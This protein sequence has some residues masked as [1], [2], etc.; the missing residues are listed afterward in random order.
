NF[1]LIRTVISNFIDKIKS[2]Q[3]PREREF[4]EQIKTT[5]ISI[6]DIKSLPLVKKYILKMKMQLISVIKN[7]DVKIKDDLRDQVPLPPC[8]KDIFELTESMSFGD[9]S[10]ALAEAGDVER[11][12]EVAI[13]I[14]DVDGQALAFGDIS[15]TLAK[16]G[17]VE[18]ALEVAMLISDAAFED[19]SN[20]QELAFGDIS[21][22]LAEAGDVER[23]LEV[24]M[25]IPGVDR[26]ES[27]FAGISTALAQAGNVGRAVEVAR[28]I[29][30]VCSQEWA[31]V[32]ISTTLA[33]AGDV[34]RATE[35]AQSILDP[36]KK[37]QALACIRAPSRRRL[38][39]THQ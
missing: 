5:N 3:F 21:I 10:K 17:D 30:D 13:S 32:C 31:F 18:R 14:P 8:I 33:K 26:Q 15:K 29:S 27:A 28:F 19:I 37:A 4:L 20:R 39:Y 36:F 2:E 7:L 24:A 25:L 23:A 1:G 35:I 34:E 16:A 12:L 9:I 11:A 38:R 6:K 22:A